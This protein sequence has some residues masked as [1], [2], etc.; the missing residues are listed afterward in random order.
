MWWK[1]KNNHSYEASPSNRFKGKGCPYCSNR[2]VLKGYNDLQTL[3]PDKSIE[4]DYEKNGDLKPTDVTAHSSKKVF[5]KCKYGHCWKT[6]IRDR[7]SGG[8]NCPH[9]YQIARK[10]ILK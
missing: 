8:T 3:Y 2:K 1:C 4:W 6:S 10:K 9:C 7:T 5:W